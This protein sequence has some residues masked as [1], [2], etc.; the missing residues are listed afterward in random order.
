[1]SA[2]REEQS[3]RTSF[4]EAVKTIMAALKEE[5]SLSVNALSRE[6]Q[7]KNCGKSTEVAP[8]HPT[9]FPTDKV[10]SCCVRLEK[11]RRGK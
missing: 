10:E 4:P 6:T 8:R 3:E 9:I 11:T 1:M 2:V 7:Q 5:R